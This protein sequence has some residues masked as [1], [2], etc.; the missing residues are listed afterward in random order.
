[1]TRRTADGW[2]FTERAYEI[3]YVDHSPLTGSAPG[4]GAETADPPSGP[5]P[6]AGGR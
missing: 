2:K 1:M 5:N 3:R 4:A 6:P